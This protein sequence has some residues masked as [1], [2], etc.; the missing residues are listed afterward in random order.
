MTCA[1]IVNGVLSKLAGVE[2]ADVS[3]NNALVTIKLKP[4][5][6][7]SVP[8]LWQLL[9]KKG[10]TP[11]ATTV[12]V[13]GD[14]VNPN[15]QLQLKV[16]GTNDITALIQDPKNPAAF[17]GATAKVGQTAIIHGVMMP[18]KDLKAPAPLHVSDVK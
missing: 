15:G 2:S 7:V 18:A 9:R 5:N 13:R 14:L 17:G 3:L 12:S 16:A 10:Y 11:K 6:T 1:H 4:G 8:Q